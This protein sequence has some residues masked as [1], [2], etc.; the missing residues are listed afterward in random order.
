MFTSRHLTRELSLVV[1]VGILSIFLFA[2]PSGPYPA[3]H[4][5]VTALRALHFSIAIL[6]SIAIAVSM[7]AWM[8]ALPIAVPWWL[9]PGPDLFI[10][11]SLCLSTKLR[12]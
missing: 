4:G 1:I 2:A 11:Q 7:L 6:W 9:L 8:L 12:C 10:S 5:P 3:V